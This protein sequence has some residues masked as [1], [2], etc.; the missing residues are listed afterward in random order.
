MDKWE[1]FKAKIVEQKKTL[2]ERR[3]MVRLEMSMAQ[4]ETEAS[5]V[6][7]SFQILIS[8]SSALHDNLIVKMM[9]LIIMNLTRTLPAQ[10]VRNHFIN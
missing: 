6:D 1:S 3:G 2:Q 8:R 4:R 7:L 9:K 10:L 5:S